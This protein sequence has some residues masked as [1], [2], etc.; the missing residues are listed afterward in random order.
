M[1]FAGIY[2]G[3]SNV[4][5]HEN[6]DSIWNTS[7]LIFSSFFSS[8]HI[9]F[10]GI[11]I[12][13]TTRE[14]GSRERSSLTHTFLSVLEILILVP[15]LL[16]IYS[17]LQLS[18]YTLSRASSERYTTFNVETTSAIVLLQRSCINTMCNTFEGIFPYCYSSRTLI[19]C[20]IYSTNQKAR[21][22]RGILESCCWRQITSVLCRTCIISS[23][24]LVAPRATRM[25]RWIT[26]NWKLWSSKTSLKKCQPCQRDSRDARR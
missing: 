21:C 2:Y 10:V 19:S 15:W 11:D 18:Q 6:F 4:E 20:L 9:S 22:R 1:S 25:C 24:V 16:Y 5:K 26:H 3:R 23:R 14:P 12:N 8:V 13:T 7:P 17:F